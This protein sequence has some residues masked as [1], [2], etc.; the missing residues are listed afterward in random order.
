[1][2]NITEYWIG[3][4]VD[5]VKLWD[6]YDSGK[7][8]YSEK[9]HSMKVS[10]VKIE[11]A[12]PPTNEPLFNLEVIYKTFK[13]L[14][15]DFKNICL[16]NLNE[17]NKAGPLFV[18]SIERGSGWWHLLIESSYA[19]QFIIPFA[20]LALQ[21][22]HEPFLIK[23][24]KLEIEKLEEERDIRNKERLENNKQKIE[25]SDIDKFIYERK[26]IIEKLLSQGIKSIVF[27]ERITINFNT[28]NKIKKEEPP[29][30]SK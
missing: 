8:G 30:H 24:T 10:Q 11:F 23:K 28:S 9:F 20:Y 27:E 3:E 1:M 25:Q 7:E 5:Y 18:Y 29:R 21:I 14:Y 16:A 17:R 4:N 12:I 13:G 2:S 19:A 26:P 15:Y 6:S 22:Y